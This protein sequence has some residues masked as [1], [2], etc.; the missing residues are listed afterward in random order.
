[1][2]DPGRYGQLD[3]IQGKLAHGWAV[4]WLKKD[5]PGIVDVFIDGDPVG[6][7]VSDRFRGDLEQAKIRD[8]HAGFVFEIPDTYW[9]GETHV[10]DV[11]H[12]R[13][14]ES[15]QES[16]RTFQI[17]KPHIGVEQTEAWKDVNVVL[18]DDTTAKGFVEALRGSRRVALFSTFH[19]A[20]RFLSY[21]DT[22]VQSLSER[23]FVTVIV[24]A[25]AAPN[26]EI[27]PPAGANRF[28]I[29]K[30]NIGYDFGS[31]AVALARLRPHLASIDELVLLNDSVIPVDRDWASVLPDIR[32]AGADVVGLTDSYEHAYHLQSYFLWLSAPALRSDAFHEFMSLGSFGSI[33]SEAIRTGELAL[34]KRLLDAGFSIHA[35]VECGE[36]AASWLDAV[37]SLVTE[38]ESLPG[39]TSLAGDDY[40]RS[41]TKRTSKIIHQLAKGRPINPTHFFWDTLIERF[42]FPF[43][44]RELVLSN[45]CGIPSYFRI[46]RFLNDRSDARRMIKELRR[47]Y[48]G[49]LLPIY[50][51]PGRRT[52]PSPPQETPARTALRAI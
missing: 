14:G 23:G 39:S 50:V 49:E 32:A 10:L 8:G 41:L 12:H 51:P 4:A 34:T 21:H 27:V 46:G 42:R 44:K 45:P 35:M 15:L 2:K 3:K 6:S 13:T 9:D 48:G 43:I 52:V 36:V 29:V 5:S 30:R 22:L 40:R 31:W 17:G 38:I 47:S 1:M 24:H 33:K 19:N 25:S 7:I 26:I 20:S 28:T 37:D 16:P 18:R 11:R